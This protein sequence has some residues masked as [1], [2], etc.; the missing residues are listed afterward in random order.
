MPPRIEALDLS[1]FVSGSLQGEPLPKELED[2]LLSRGSYG[3]PCAR[4]HVPR[5]TRLLVH[6]ILP[7]AWGGQDVDTN[8]VTLCPTTWLAVAD[9][10][11]L[12]QEGGAVRKPPSM[13]T[14]PYF[15]RKLAM[16]AFWQFRHVS[17]LPTPPRLDLTASLPP[18]PAPHT[19]GAPHDDAQV[20]GRSR[21]GDVEV[22]EPTE[23]PI[24]V[25]LD[26]SRRSVALF[27]NV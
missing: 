16:A 9:L 11:T 24:E 8:R 13:K 7:L 20:L 6:H 23:G 12:L 10:M 19:V 3:C 1:A 4:V 17:P 15:A 26:E 22:E 2:R 5:P 18:H 14:Y 21:M 25:Q 27:G